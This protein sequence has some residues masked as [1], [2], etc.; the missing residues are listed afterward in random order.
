MILLKFLKK[1]LKKQQKKTSSNNFKK[2][3][4]KLTMPSVSKP[5]LTTIIEEPSQT[6]TPSKTNVRKTK[7][8]SVACTGKRCPKGYK[9]N[10]LTR[11]C[12]SKEETE[13]LFSTIFSIPEEEGNTKTKSKTNTKIR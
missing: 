7:S 8:K 10:Q 12:D 9:Y 13:K 5:K 1:L 11:E 3:T 2:L 4:R 6:K